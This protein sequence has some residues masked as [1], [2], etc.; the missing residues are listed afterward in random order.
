MQRGREIPRQ[1]TRCRG[2]GRTCSQA[3]Q[4]PPLTPPLGSRGTVSQLLYSQS[5]LGAGR[6][7]NTRAIVASL[8]SSCSVT[9]RHR[10]GRKGL[11]NQAHVSGGENLGTLNQVN[12]PHSGTRRRQWIH[13]AAPKWIHG[14]ARTG[15]LPIDSVY[16]RKIPRLF[17]ACFLKPVKEK[18][19][20]RRICL[21]GMSGD[22]LKATRSPGVGTGEG[23]PVR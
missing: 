4:A 2:G 18:K 10:R 6:A 17:Q 20:L 12:A 15:R 19:I 13:G 11:I 16:Q 8:F 22:E 7:A 5:T 14:A 3:R 9:D 21:V 23:R 1:Q